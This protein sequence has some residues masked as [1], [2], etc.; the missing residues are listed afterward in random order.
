MDKMEANYDRCG[1]IP[2]IARKRRDTDTERYY[3][4]Y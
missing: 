3:T 4:Y 1:K 2:D